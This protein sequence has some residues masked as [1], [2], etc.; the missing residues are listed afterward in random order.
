MST[1]LA[2][3]DEKFLLLGNENF[4]VPRSPAAP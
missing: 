3:Y 2:E 1:G 4:P